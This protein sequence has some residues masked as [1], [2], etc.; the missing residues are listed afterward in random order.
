MKLIP[1]LMILATCLLSQPAW[2]QCAS[3]ANAG[4][5][6]VP[7]PDQSYSPLNGSTQVWPPS[8]TV[9]AD[10]WGAIAADGDSGD[11]GNSEEQASESIAVNAAMARCKRNGAKHCEVVLTFYNQCA[12]AVWGGGTLTA[13]GSPT[14]EQA[15]QLAIAKCGL[16]DACKIIYSACSPAQRIQ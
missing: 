15:K 5:A 9:W 8:H 11:A 10:R 14:V 6:C 13:A 3:G 16:G 1:T 2:P 7:P 4:G 12:A